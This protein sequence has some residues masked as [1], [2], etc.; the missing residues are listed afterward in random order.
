MG[1]DIIVVVGLDTAPVSADVTDILIITTEGVRPP[2]VYTSLEDIKVDWTEN[3]IAYNKAR[4]L[5]E[6]GAARP[7]PSGL[8]RKV[9]II[10]FDPPNVPAD[11]IEDIQNLQEENDDWYVFL[12]D[13]TDD[14]YVAAL[15]EYAEKSEP[16]KS[17]LS[18]GEEDRRKIYFGQTSNKEMAVERARSAIVY[19]ENEEEHIDAA[20]AGAVLPWYPRAVTWKF[21]M[22]AGVSVPKL[23]DSEVSV[24]EKNRIN[25]VCNEYKRNYIKHGWCT[26]GNWIDAVIG[27]DWLAKTIRERLYDV[28]QNNAVVPYDDQGFTQ[29]AAAVI[30]AFEAA[31]GHGIIMR[32]PESGLGT[33]EIRIPRRSEATEAEAKNR[34]MPDMSWTAVLG[35]AI[36]GVTITGTLRVSL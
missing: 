34:V 13:Q 26:D 25:F 28:F 11:L 23:T 10:G 16:T 32:N 29:V 31:T 36:H 27:G 9:T 5:F 18:T 15:A 19:T 22:P 30:G 1:K 17:A 7:V 33:Y 4:A 6:Q 24:L 35:G 3:S 14:I 12:T 21:K 2:K 20:W 8:I